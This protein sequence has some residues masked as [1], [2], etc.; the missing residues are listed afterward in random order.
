MAAFERKYYKTVST[1][2]TDT[3]DYIITNGSK[4][5][6]IQ[7]GGNS[8]FTSD[9]Y[10]Q[11]V[12]DPDGSPEILYSTYGSN[13]RNTIIELTGD[14]S[15]KLQIKLVNNSLTSHVMG[16]FYLGELYA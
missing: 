7:L 15:K 1:L 4:L 16:G 9:V 5:S 13:V 6:L 11:V 10:I 3:D 2:N 12:W 8:V 14:G